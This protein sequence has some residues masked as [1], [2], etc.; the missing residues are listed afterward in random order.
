MPQVSAP[1]LP[2]GGNIPANNRSLRAGVRAFPRRP[3]RSARRKGIRPAGCRAQGPKLA[4]A[5]AAVKESKAQ[6]EKVREEAKRA[7]REAQE[8]ELKSLQESNK[9]KEEALAEARSG[10]LNL[11]RRLREAE[12][13]GKT[14]NW[15][16]S[17]SSM[18]SARPSP[19]AS[20]WRRG[21]ARRVAQMKT[22]IEQAQREAADL[23]RKLEQGSQQVQGEALELGL[24]AMLREAFPLDVIEAVPKGVTGA[25]LLQ[26]VCSASGQVCGTIVWE[27]KQTK[28]WNPSWLRKLKDDQRAVGAEIAVIVTAAMPKECAGPSCGSTMSGSRSRGRAAVAE[29]LR[30]TLHRNAQAAPGQPRPQ[31]EDGARLQLPLQ[32]A[33]RPA[34]EGGRR[35]RGDDAQRAR[36]RKKGVHPDLAEARAPVERMTGCMVAIVGDLQG[37]GD[38]ALP[39]LDSIAALPEPERLGEVASHH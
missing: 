31:R 23:K 12:D 17:G 36:R 25:D 6:I 37:I 34:D 35:E 16:T 30:A 7:A 4:E 19:S 22:Q 10:E 11:R 39:Q 24:E 38:G 26:R 9:A 29:A 13:A 15:R 8:T 33:I 32:P 3:R 5:D 27:T 18:P 2:A 20:A 14:P 28:G 1:I 21:E